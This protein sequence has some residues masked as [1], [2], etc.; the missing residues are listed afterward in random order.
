VGLTV[1]ELSG[2]VTAADYRETL[3]SFYKDTEPTLNV[4]YDAR[5][6]NWKNV[7]T[8]EVLQVIREAMRAYQLEV[9]PRAG[10]KTAVVVNHEAGESLVAMA[11]MLLATSKP[12]PPFEL[13][14]FSDMTKASGWLAAKPTK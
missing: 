1:H 14:V 10:G 3:R 11:Q 13:A 7:P 5:K 6:L 12:S 8:G 2:N 4:L 9:Q